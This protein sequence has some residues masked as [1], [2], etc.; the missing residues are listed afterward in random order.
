[1]YVAHKLKKKKEENLLFFVKA[2]KYILSDIEYSLSARLQQF[3]KPTNIYIHAYIIGA[4]I[5]G[6]RQRKYYIFST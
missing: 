4:L 6:K 5:G 3:K 1:M 2:I